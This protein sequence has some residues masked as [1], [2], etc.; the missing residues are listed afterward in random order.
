MGT[1]TKPFDCVEMKHEAQARL[2][3]EYEA[4]KTDFDSYVAFLQWKAEHS[5]IAQTIHR[6]IASAASA[7]ADKGKR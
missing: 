7:R 4:R 3:A 2:H 1:K 6:K 5:E